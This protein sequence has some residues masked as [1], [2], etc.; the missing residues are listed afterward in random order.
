MGWRLGSEWQCHYGQ[1]H[2]DLAL[3]DTR[4]EVRPLSVETWSSGEGLRDRKS[5]A[6]LST[7]AKAQEQRRWPKGTL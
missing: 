6:S 5:S 1:S 2:L 3:G 4:G 7:L